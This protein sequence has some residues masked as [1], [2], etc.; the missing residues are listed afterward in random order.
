VRHLTSFSGG[1]SGDGYSPVNIYCNG[2]ALALNYDPAQHHAR[3]HTYVDDYWPIH[4]NAGANTFQWTAG[5]LCS[6]YWI[7]MLEITPTA[8]LNISGISLEPAKVVTFQVTGTSTNVG[9]LESSTNLINWTLALSV[10]AFT[11]DC[12]ISITNTKTLGRQFFRLNF[13]H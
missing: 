6:R 13:P 8:P 5:S 1:C 2:A 4:L 12:A 9:W 3:V 7:Q 11:N 10:P